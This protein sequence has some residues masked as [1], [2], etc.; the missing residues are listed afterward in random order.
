MF[1]FLRR[2]QWYHLFGCETNSNRA[3]TAQSWDYLV[4][5]R[6]LAAHKG[7]LPHE[8]MMSQSALL[9]WCHPLTVR[10][11]MKYLHDDISSPCA[12]LLILAP[13]QAGTLPL[14]NIIH[15][16]LWDCLPL[17]VTNTFP[18]QTLCPTFET[19]P[20]LFWAKLLTHFFMGSDGLLIC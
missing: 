18:P 6:D 14:I 3:I 17:L 10:N 5:L 19:K 8:R 13:E 9:L 11:I 1:N 16:I 15:T 12:S 20:Q 7:H 4:Y 2:Q